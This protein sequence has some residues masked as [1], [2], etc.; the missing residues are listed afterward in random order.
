M[1]KKIENEKLLIK[2][3]KIY[4]EV[5]IVVD[6]VNGFAREGMLASPLVDAIV[7]N[8]V[9]YVEEAKK[10]NRLI[11]F[12]KDTHDKD[13]VEFRRFGDEPHCLRGT[14][15]A[16]LVDELVPYEEETI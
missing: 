5:L 1:E 15:E 13:S 14:R 11:I 12:I 3:L 4:E 10:E 2:N 9:E 8:V 7:P 16:Q 6:M